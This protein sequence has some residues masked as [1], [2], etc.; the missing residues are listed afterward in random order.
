MPLFGLFIGLLMTWHHDTQLY[1][2]GVQELIGCTDSAQV[3]C[4]IVN[5]SAYSELLG[6]PIASLAV[7]LYGTL[8]GLVVLALRGREGAHTLILAGGVRS[9]LTAV[10]LFTISKTELHYVCAWCLRSYGVDAAILVLA[11]AAG[12]LPWPSRALLLQAGGLLL[13][14]MLLAIGGERLFRAPLSGSGGPQ[15]AEQAAERGQDPKGQAPPL[16]FTVQTEK[17]KQATFQLD[18]DDAWTGNRDA[19]VAVVMF[20]DLECGYCKRARAE[21]GRLEAS[22]GDRVLFV[23]KHFPM[24]TACNP[25]VSHDLHR[26]ACDAAKAAVCAQDQGRFWAFHDRAYKNQHDLSEPSLRAYA[27]QAGAEGASLDACMASQAPLEVVRH[28]AEVGASLDIHGTPRIFIDGKLYRSGSS[29]ESMAR[30]LETA[31]GATPQQAAQRA[32]AQ[33]EAAGAVAPVPADL[34][35]MQAESLGGLAFRIDTFEASIVNGAATVG[36]HQ[37]PAMGLSWAQARDAC[38]QAGKRLCT[39]EEWVSACQGA[40]AVD[41]NGNGQFADDMIEGTAYPY[42]DDH[43]EHR[44]WDDMRGDEDRPVYSGE[45]P[46]CVTAQGVYDLTGN[47]EEWVGDSAQTAV[48]LG[49]AWDTPEDHARCYRRNDTFGPGYKSARTGFRCCA[50]AAP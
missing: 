12:R 25:G 48:L 34:P 30:T 13:A 8:L 38:A 31:L 21:L 20:G 15:V 33:R 36:K 40:R 29:A 49:G 23:C 10:L 19:R 18:P 5:T 46:G 45:L 14:M 16:S 43:D 9:V 47:V 35:P 3:N 1:G 11:L 2:T 22:Y 4:N 27:I 39:K 6:I 28:D 50:D 17:G 42:G 44:C 37:V 32:G 41:D 26:S 24:N 7:G